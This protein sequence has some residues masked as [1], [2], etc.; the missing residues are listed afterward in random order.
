[1]FASVCPLG[2]MAVDVNHGPARR[3][4]H[5]QPSRRLSACPWPSPSGPALGSVSRPAV[6]EATQ[7]QWPVRVSGFLVCAQHLQHTTCSRCSCTVR[8]PALKSASGHRLG[9]RRSCRV[10]VG[11]YLIWIHPVPVKRPKSAPSLTACWM[12]HVS[13]GHVCPDSC[14]VSSRFSPN[15]VWLWAPVD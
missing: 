2:Q 1:M 8:D 14:R 5:S 10:Q 13:P 9:G 6:R 12:S 15:T 3:E 7:C 11:T 4:A